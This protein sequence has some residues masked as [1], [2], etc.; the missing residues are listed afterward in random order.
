ML[1]I[2]HGFLLGLESVLLCFHVTMKI[3][4]VIIGHIGRY[5]PSLQGADGDRGS[6]ITGFFVIIGPW[7]RFLNGS[8]DVTPVEEEGYL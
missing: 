7:K 1:N 8:G 2:V 6:V 4:I 3:I 5:S